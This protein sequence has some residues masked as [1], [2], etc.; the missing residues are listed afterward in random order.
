[1]THT[2]QRTELKVIIRRN[3]DLLNIVSTDRNTL[4]PSTDEILHSLTVFLCLNL[5]VAD[6][7]HLIFQ[8]FSVFKTATMD[9]L[10]Q[11]TEQEK[12][13]GTE[14]RGLRGMFDDIDGEL[15]QNFTSLP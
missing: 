2:K 1:M 7:S 9:H 11:S 13:T 3:R 8:D 14:T 5:P 12:V 10:L 6:S 15:I 4:L